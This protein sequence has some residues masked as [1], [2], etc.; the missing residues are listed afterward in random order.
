MYNPNDKFPSEW[1]TFKGKKVSSDTIDHQHLSNCYWYL[2]VI[3]AV[4]TDHSM[5]IGI[6]EKLA[7][8][9]NGQLLPYRPHVDFEY[10]VSGR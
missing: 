5:M 4:P 2:L 8:R 7:E 9:F 10:K 1:V 6:K 3:H